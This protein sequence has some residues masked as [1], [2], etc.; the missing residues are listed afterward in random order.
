MKEKCSYVGPCFHSFLLNAGS[1]L[2]INEVVYLDAKLAAQLQYQDYLV[3][4]FS[5]SKLRIGTSKL[6]GGGAEGRLVSCRLVS[7]RAI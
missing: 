4:S 1:Y 3:N 5:F 6:G 7:N 2:P